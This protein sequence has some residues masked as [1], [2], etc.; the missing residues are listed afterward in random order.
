MKKIVIVLTSMLLIFLTACEKESDV[1]KVKYFTKDNI[2][3]NTDDLTLI[4]GDGV[5]FY[6]SVVWDEGGIYK[7]GESSFIVS[8]T[9]KYSE[10]DNVNEGKISDYNEYTEFIKD[11]FAEESKSELTNE[12]IRGV[13]ILKLVQIAEQKTV[14]YYLPIENGV[15]I[16]MAYGDDVKQD[17]VDEVINTVYAVEGEE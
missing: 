6:S 13:E 4:K 8:G 14:V 1:D 3:V 16:V 15:I 12:V 2:E 5:E 17:I 11:S 9:L 10:L 7:F